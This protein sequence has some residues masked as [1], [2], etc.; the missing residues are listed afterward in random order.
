MAGAVVKYIDDFAQIV[1][2]SLAH[3]APELLTQR[4]VATHFKSFFEG[5]SGPLNLSDFRKWYDEALK[6]DEF[7]DILSN[8]GVRRSLENVAENQINRQ[9]FDIEFRSLLSKGDVDERRINLLGA[10]YK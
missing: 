7:K 4:K 8:S 1:G 3:T 2:S 10:A 6:N 5:R 9:N